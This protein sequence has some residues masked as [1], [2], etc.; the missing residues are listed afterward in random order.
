MTIIACIMR[1]PLFVW[2]LI[3]VAL[4]T[5]VSAHSI[6]SQS[7]SV[8]LNSPI[9]TGVLVAQ[10]IHNGTIRLNSQ[11]SGSVISPALSCKPA[12]CALPNVQASEGGQ[13]VNDDPIA[14]NPANHKNLLTGGNDYNCASLQGFYASSDGG[15]T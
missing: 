14:I 4:T 9:S 13:P 8:L 10:A 1:G 11:A 7:N 15:T 5:P 3:F 12:P 6:D 2:L